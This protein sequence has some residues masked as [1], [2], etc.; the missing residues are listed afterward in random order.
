MPK[1]KTLKAPIC[2][3]DHVEM[4]WLNNEPTFVV[5]VVHEDGLYEL[6]THNGVEA[7]D[8]FYHP[9][10][11]QGQMILKTSDLVERVQQYAA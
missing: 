2:E 11:Y 10:T 9:Y 8:M 5:Q 3:R 1:L 6:Q 7:L 4:Y